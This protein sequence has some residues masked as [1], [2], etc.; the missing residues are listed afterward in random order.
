PAIPGRL[1]GVLKSTNGGT[2]WDALN[3]GLTNPNVLALAIDPTNP[4][5]VY[6]GTAGSGVFKSTDGAL[7]WT[8]TGQNAGSGSPP[9]VMISKVSGDNQTGAAGQPLRNPFVVTVTNSNG[10]PVAGTSVSFAITGGD[11]TL[12]STSFTTDSQGVAL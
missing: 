10:V 1:A 5:T 2:S 11:G 4:A 6:A 9:V 3:S 7:T 12:T 8:P